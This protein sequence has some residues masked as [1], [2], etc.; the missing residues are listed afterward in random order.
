VKVDLRELDW[1]AELIHQGFD[2]NKK[3]VILAEGVF[4]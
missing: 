4:M 2:K 3:T 1:M